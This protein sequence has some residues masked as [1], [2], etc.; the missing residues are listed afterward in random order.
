MA[1]DDSRRARTE[2]GILYVMLRRRY[3][4]S[5]R[6]SFTSLEDARR[7]HFPPAKNSKAGLMLT[8]SHLDL[9]IAQSAYKVLKSPKGPKTQNDAEKED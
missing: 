9:G 6:S 2:G 3:I 5:Q 7:F 4:F 8:F 1:E